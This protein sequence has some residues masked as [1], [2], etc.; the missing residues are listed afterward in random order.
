VH[1]TEAQADIR[2]AYVGGG[3]GAIV[4]SLVWFAAAYAE[5]NYGTAFAFKLLFFGGF[6]IFPVSA[7]A[8]FLFFRRD[9]PAADNP[10][11]LIALESTIAM[12]GC[13]FAAWLLLPHRPDYVF[14][15]AAIAVGT[16]YFA[17]KS[18]YGDT[19][20]W[21]LAAAITLVGCAGIFKVMPIPGG[22][23]IAVA[24]IELIFGIV[25]TARSMKVAA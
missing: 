17:F 14:P 6:L 11:G 18:V 15:I 22:T 19:L 16:H 23:I 12:I 9:K 8:E 1:I 10:L 24:V 5:P 7:L 4:S 20:Y 3:L 2:R 13:L 21:A 25:L